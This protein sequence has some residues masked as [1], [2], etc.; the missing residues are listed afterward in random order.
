MFHTYLL[1]IFYMPGKIALLMGERSQRQ[2]EKFCSL[3]DDNKVPRTKGR[4]SVG[5]V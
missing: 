1:D 4:W 3:A 5:S 2:E